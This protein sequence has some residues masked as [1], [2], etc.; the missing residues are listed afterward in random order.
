MARPVE[1]LL[2]ESVEGLGIIGDVVTVRAGHARNYLLPHGLAE[3][4]TP[5]KIEALTEARR[6]AQADLDRI[7][8]LR[9]ELLERIEGLEIAI[10]RS[11]NA[12][13]VLYG[14]VTQRD[15]ADELQRS[16]YDVGTRSIRLTASIRRIGVYPV[17]VQFDKDLQAEITLEVKPDQPLEDREEMEFDDEGNLIEK[18]TST[19]GEGGEGGESGDS[20]EAAIEPDAGDVQ[21]ESSDEDERIPAGDED[22][23]T[24]EDA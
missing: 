23:S 9:E 19:G 24:A 3:P 7:R 5:D 15:I 18:P 4:P 22:T 16:G 2:L 20:G 14:S 13:G 21:D 6:D 17:P 8:G 11:C 12:R 10:T 1:L